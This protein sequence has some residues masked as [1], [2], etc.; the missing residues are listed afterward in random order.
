MASPLFRATPEATYG[1]RP[2]IPA[3]PIVVP[4]VRFTNTLTDD[5][6]L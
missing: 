2:S 5:G 1:P 4:R 3:G 6:I